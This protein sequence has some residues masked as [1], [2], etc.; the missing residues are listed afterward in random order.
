MSENNRV[1]MK[2]LIVREYRLIV[3]WF[4]SV[5]QADVIVNSVPGNLHIEVINPKSASYSISR[6]AGR[7]ALASLRLVFVGRFRNVLHLRNNFS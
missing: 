1:I 3:F 6:A 7:E 2:C 5:L 4:I